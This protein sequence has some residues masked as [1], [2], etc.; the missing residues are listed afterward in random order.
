MDGTEGE[1]ADRRPMAKI[2][3]KKGLEEDPLRAHLMEQ[4][5]RIR[6]TLADYDQTGDPERLHAARTA[7]RRLRALLRLFR[8]PLRSTSA[9]TISGNL[10]SL[11]RLLGKARDQDVWIE[12]LE[13]YG[14]KLKLSGDATWCA[15]LHDQYSISHTC[16][17]KARVELQSEEF[18]MLLRQSGDMVSTESCGI[19][20]GGRQEFSCHL[21]NRL[22]GAIGD[23]LE[24]HVRRKDVSEKRLHRF[25]RKCRQLR[26]W[27]ELARG[28][29]G[30]RRTP[31]LESFR[32]FSTTLGQ[33]RDADLAL[34]RLQRV[35]ADWALKIAGQLITRKKQNLRAL[36]K[37]WEACRKVRFRMDPLYRKSRKKSSWDS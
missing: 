29:F 23:I 28:Q 16:H 18:R 1:T 32:F 19:L 14:K 37:E 25:R 15:Y 5:E 35:H 4:W 22:S 8:K 17:R 31:F 10:R 24:D 3:E 26:Y 9:E 2:R 11:L 21:A 33:T 20:A 13:Q 6:T 34:R 27:S 30:K 12:I 36:R 7:I